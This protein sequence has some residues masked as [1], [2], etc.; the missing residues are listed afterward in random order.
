MYTCRK[1]NFVQLSI[2]Q[3]F[4]DYNSVFM[5]NSITKLI[6]KTPRNKVL[7][8][9]SR[10]CLTVSINF[11]WKSRGIKY[12]C[13]CTQRLQRMVIVKWLTALRQLGLL[14]GIN[15]RTMVDIKLSCTV[16]T[17]TNFNHKF[18]GRL[19]VEEKYY[20]AVID[21]ET[22]MEYLVPTTT[23]AG[24]CTTALVDFLTLVHNNFIERCR[25]LTAGNDPK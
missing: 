22:P 4:P 15:W 6:R 10:N 1:Q 2:Y 25:A 7:D 23:E 13:L 19:P 16:Y 17:S 14:W 18:P 24:V 8:N 21:D 5:T 9:L 20:V 11:H 12:L 3:R